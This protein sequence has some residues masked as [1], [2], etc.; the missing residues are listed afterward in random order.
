MET[1]KKHRSNVILLAL[2]GLVALGGGGYWLHHRADA[3]DLPEAVASAALTASRSDGGGDVLVE[4]ARVARTR[5]ADEA[6]AV[7]TLKSNESVVLRPETSGRINRIAFQDG[8]RVKKGVLLLTLDAGIQAAE[9]QQA[10]ANLA[11]ARANQTRNEDLFR[12][13]FISPQALD[14]TR[15]A[16]R[17]QEAA[18][19]LAR[20]RLDKMQIRAPFDGVMGIRNVSVGDYIR[21][22]ED[23]VNLEDI[24]TLKVDFRLPEAYLNRLRVGLGLEVMSDALPNER[25]SASLSALDPLVDVGG[26][27]ISCRALLPNGEGRL[28]PGMFVRVRLDFGANV[29]TLMIPEEAVVTGSAPFVFRVETE[30][31]TLTV[32]TIPVRLGQHRAGQVEILEGLE[33][34]AEVVTSGHLKLRD[35]AVV[36]RQEA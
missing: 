33:D 1:K 13:K 30:G 8:E 16:L 26:R 20:A 35:G 22:G 17:V 31:R 9:L 10:E 32:K 6:T 5:L 7:G 14:N 18:V 36:K 11:L 28:H 4:T 2:A 27:S 21:E 15:A 3:P 19:T 25:F 24:N 34:N 29:D 12:K 23:L